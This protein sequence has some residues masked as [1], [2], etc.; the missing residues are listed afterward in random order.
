MNKPTCFKIGLENERM[1]YNSKELFEYNP[2]FYYGCKTKPRTIVQ[3]KKIPENEYVYANIK[4]DEWKLTTEKCKK[5]QLLISKEW[6]EKYYFTKKPTTP[7]VLTEEKEEQINVCEDDFKEEIIEDA[8]PVL[9][10]KDEEKFKDCDGN[11][12]E[13]ETRGERLEDKIYFKVKDVSLVFGL[14]SL[15]E[16]LLHKEKGYERNVDYKNLFIRNRSPNGQSD[17]IKKCL[18]L[19]YE[20]LLRVLFVSRNKYV[21]TFRKWAT[22]KLFTIQMGSKDEKI[23]LGT[24]ILNISVKTYKAVF[25]TYASKFPCIYLLSLGKV[26]DLRETFGIDGGVLD[27][28]TVYKFGFTDDLERRLGEHQVKYGKLKNVNINLS[29]FHIVDVKYTSEAESEIRDFFTAFSK[30]LDIKGY[31]E[32]VAFT[33]KEYKQITRQ[34]K[35]IGEQYTGNTAGFK[36]EINDLNKK[37]QDLHDEMKDLN[38]IIELKDRDLLSNKRIYE[39]EIMNRDMQIKLLKNGLID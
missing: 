15:N 29:C 6:V 28:S 4:S 14:P 30:S 22:N 33:S 13:I 35:S 3:K 24:D 5:A 12:T 36:K 34:Y 23:K 20:G 31:N 11:I 39:L 32:L 2:L 1:Y 8:P 7:S 27:D 19:T 10:L 21:S 38:H 26:K 9:H 25:E 16:V 18:Y 37:I 17:T